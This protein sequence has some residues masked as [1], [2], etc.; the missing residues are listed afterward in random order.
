MMLSHKAEDSEQI[1]LTCNIYILLI[2]FSNVCMYVF[3]YF[4][5]EQR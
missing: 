2:D 3:M 5:R 4:D 1:P